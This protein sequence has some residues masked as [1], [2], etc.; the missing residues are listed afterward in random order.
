MRIALLEIVLL[1]ALVGCATESNPALD[2]TR[3]TEIDQGVRRMLDDIAR[4]LAS[5]GPTAWTRYFADSPDFYMASDG[6][7]VF[8]TIE[9]AKNFL[10]EFAPN[11]SSMS[12]T[13]SDVRVDPAA[14]GLAL[15]A[16]AYHEVIVEVSGTE[17]EFG[18]YFTGVATETPSGWRLRTLHWSSPESNP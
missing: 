15:V 17:I 3:A 6:E 8:P 16:A 12:L 11:V 13:W 14:E 4:D 5:D 9:D 1:L 18:G 10:R 2:A 7:L